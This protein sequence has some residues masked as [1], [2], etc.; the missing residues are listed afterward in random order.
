MLFLFTVMSAVTSTF[1][2]Q[3]SHP[4]AMG[5]TLIIQTSIVCLVSG[6]N[7]KSMWLPY[8]LMMIFLGAM[9]VLFMYVASLAANEPFYFTL[10]PVFLFFLTLITSLIV[11][12]I[13]DN[14]YS[15]SG[16]LSLSKSSIL[17][18]NFDYLFEAKL[19]M[20]YNTHIMYIT[21]FII[22]Y[23]LLTLIVVVK[24]TYTFMGPLRLS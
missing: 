20:L 9:L 18:N 17:T 16:A 3:T 15:Y 23:L 6:I 12:F 8:I 4:L 21:L 5:M 2:T 14:V 19:S 11:V 13:M 7:I 10:P 24:L 22:L 1:F